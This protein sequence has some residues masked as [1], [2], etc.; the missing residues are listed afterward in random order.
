MQGTGETG[1]TGGTYGQRLFRRKLHNVSLATTT[2]ILTFGILSNSQDLHKT[3]EKDYLDDLSTWA[4]GV[5]ELGT[6]TMMFAVARLD[7]I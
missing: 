3:S 4:S 5:D 7:N 6:M 2:E 1:A